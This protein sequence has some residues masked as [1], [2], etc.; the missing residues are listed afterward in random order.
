MAI[1]QEDILAR[2]Q[3]IQSAGGGDTAA[4]RAQ[5]A[6]EAQQFGVTPEQ[7]GRA[8]NLSGSQVR[9]LAEEAGQAFAPMQMTGGMLGVN[10]ID[11]TTPVTPVTTQTGM[12]EGVTVDVPVRAIDVARD[13][14]SGKISAGDAQTSLQEIVGGEVDPYKSVVA[15]IWQQTT[16]GILGQNVVNQYADLFKQDVEAGMSPEDTARKYIGIAQQTPE[17]EAKVLQDYNTALTEKVQAK[18]PIA[19][20]TLLY[21]MY[22]SGTR[23]RPQELES[24]F[25]PGEE[26]YSLAQTAGNIA[27]GL[28]T[29]D[30]L[31]TEGNTKEANN[32]LKRI[33]D[34]PQGYAQ[35]VGGDPAKLIRQNVLTEDTFYGRSSGGGGG[36]LKGAVNWVVDDALGL[37]DS[38]GLIGS[39]E[40]M[41][42]DGNPIETLDRWKN[43]GP[44]YV[45][46]AT[47]G[48]VLSGGNPAGATA[49]LSVLGANNTLDSGE[50]LSTAQ[51]IGLALNGANILELGN[52]MFT[53]AGGGELGAG[54]FTE[55]SIMNASQNF[56]LENLDLG[57]LGT[58]AQ[59]VSE[60][61]EVVQQ[62][63]NIIT[64]P[65]A[66]IADGIINKLGGASA[67]VDKLGITSQ[68]VFVEGISKGVASA[69]IAEA[70]NKNPITAFL[71]EIKGLE[72]LLPNLPGSSRFKEYYQQAS[73][74]VASFEDY[75]RDQGFDPGAI[76]EQVAM[77]EDWSKK[78]VY[79][80]NELMSTISSVE[81][82]ITENIDPAPIEDAVRAAGD[83]IADAFEPVKD[84]LVETG[85][86]I[87]DLG[88]AIADAVPDLPD[89]SGGAPVVT[90]AELEGPTFAAKRGR[91]GGLAVDTEF[92]Y[93]E[94]S[95]AL[96]ILEG[97]VG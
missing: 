95:L 36:F 24:I 12:L 20:G 6:Q 38:G 81:D 93:E 40:R 83:T 70:T 69:A 14:K 84:A 52:A 50:S 73:D 49:A 66:A 42:E 44:A 27:Q 63:N 94:P 28:A 53:A 57:S 33:G 60:A 16:G 5:I 79:D 3:Q 64:E 74:Y 97:R 75:L 89:I 21:N 1:S 55:Q 54:F 10:T 17:Y 56:G 51:I 22:S 7:I 76:S 15:D 37:D 65:V 80:P 25:G 29:A 34:D 30:Q 23:V 46:A 67:L 68:G 58:G 90:M 48:F 77:V 91:Q 87:A 39:V 9:T 86:D 35:S 62:V 18:D 13:L 43:K 31:V 32:L 72:T 41:I 82:I 96:A 45:A 78:Y 8:T 4:T 88:G 19:L 61:G 71:G 26:G 59:A 92:L 85:D 2:I 47:A 11:L